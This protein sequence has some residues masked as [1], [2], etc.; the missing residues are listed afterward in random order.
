MA[1]EEKQQNQGEKSQEELAKEWEEALKQQ[2]LQQQKEASSEE[3]ITRLISLK[4]RLGADMILTTEKDWVRLV[5]KNTHIGY[6]EVEI[7]IK[8]EEEFFAFLQN[9]YERKKNIG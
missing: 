1:E 6:I 3:D 5:D 9:A 7:A 8:K 2:E 4:K